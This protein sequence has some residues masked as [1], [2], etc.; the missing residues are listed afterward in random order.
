M[1][2]VKKSLFWLSA[3]TSTVH[4]DGQD[5]VVGAALSVV[6]RAGHFL[7]LTSQWTRKQGDCNMK[8]AGMIFPVATHSRCQTLPPV[9]L[10]LLKT[11]S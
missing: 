9:T 6:T 3:S 11:N 10:H 1:D 5:T 2:L 4:H 8:E 7:L